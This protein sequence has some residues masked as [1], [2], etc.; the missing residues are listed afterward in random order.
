[1]AVQAYRWWLDDMYMNNA[2]ALPVNSNPGMVFPPR[3]IPPADYPAFVADVAA[4]VDA[5][6]DFKDLIDRQV[7]CL[8]IIL[9]LLFRKLC[10]THH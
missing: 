6:L 7:A 4:F 5:I 3:A 8:L 2:I 10:L 9:L 1:M